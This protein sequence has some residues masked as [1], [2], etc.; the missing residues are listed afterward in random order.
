MTQA[1][2]LLAKGSEQLSSKQYEEAIQTMNQAFELKLDFSEIAD[3]SYMKARCYASLEDERALENLQKALEFKESLVNDAEQESDFTKFQS[4]SRFKSL[5]ILFKGILENYDGNYETGLNNIEQSLQINPNFSE[6]FV[7]VNSKANSLWG[8]ERYDEAIALFKE[9]DNYAADD[10]DRYT[11][12]KNLG[13]ILSES[14]RYEESILSFESAIECYDKA[15][16]AKIALPDKTDLASVFEEKGWAKSG[17]NNYQEAINSFDK[18]LE[19][20]SN[21]AWAMYG[22]AC[23][24]AALE[25]VDSALE[26]L[27]LTLGMEPEVGEDVKN[28]GEWDRIRSDSR[29]QAIVAV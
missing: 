10:L 23:C 6:Y 25:Q 4:S 8:L 7:A 13:F 19:C 15:E 11:G 29:F 12:F 20:D 26:N 14:E 3:V 17:L 5:L 28:D 9:A 18:A 22:K 16:K 1:Q 24:F 27:K 2:E 21:S